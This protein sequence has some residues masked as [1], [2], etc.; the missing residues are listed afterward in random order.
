MNVLKGAA[1]DCVLN[2]AQN[3]PDN[4]YKCFRFPV[5]DDENALAYVSSSIKDV[6]VKESKKT[7]IA[8]LKYTGGGKDLGS[9]KVDI[10]NKPIEFKEGKLKSSAPKCFDAFREK[11]MKLIPLY[12]S[13]Q[14]NTSDTFT[15]DNYLLQTATG[16]YVFPSKYI[17][18][19]T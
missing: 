9:Y 15:L 8:M 6:D 1:V 7:S 5:G 17:T 3:N 4:A 16:N 12:N 13:V 19:T 11:T 10:K 18:T 14:L 2:A